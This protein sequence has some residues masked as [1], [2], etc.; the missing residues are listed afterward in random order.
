MTIAMAFLVL[1]SLLSFVVCLVLLPF[2]RFRR[3]AKWIAA[4]S[5]LIFV[6][7]AVLFST[8]VG[9]E[10]DEAAQ[11][12][13]FVD[14]SDLRDAEAVGIK[15]AAVWK[16]RQRIAREE[17]LKASQARDEQK[18][19]ARE[20]ELKANQ[21]REDQKRAARDEELKANQARDEQ[22]RKAQEVR[23]ALL[24]PPAEQIR[25]VQAIDKGRSTYK[26]GQN[27]LQRGAARPVRAREICAAVQSSGLKQ[28]IGK[29]S[30]LSTSSDGDGVL[31]VRIA[32]DLTLTTMNNSLGDY[33]YGSLIKPSSPL[34]QKLLGMKIGET[35]RFDG[36][37]Y[38]SD[39]DCYRELSLTLG[40]SL[41][42]PDFIVNFSRVE[43]VDLPTQ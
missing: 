19:A 14:R 29:I 38:S 11:K 32:D 10:A 17:E 2:K 31:A 5:A 41:E 13:G 24:K 27:D 37:L 9:Q 43:R 28:W 21:A 26:A 3:R 30:R 4:A 23:D 42:Q 7:S 39:T 34:Y 20:E 8:G 35:V 12:R 6:V 40:G 22:R 16:E 1:L 25:F 15:D 36:Q 18:R 33:S